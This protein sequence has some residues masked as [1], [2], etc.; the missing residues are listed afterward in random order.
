MIRF[1]VATYNTHKSRGMDWRVRP[2]RIVQVLR[3][4][5]AD[6]VA[7]QE[8]IAD[9]LPWL[10]E[11]AGMAHVFGAADHIRGNEYGNLLLSRFPVL[12]SE[13]YDVSVERREPRRC[14]RVDVQ[15]PGGPLLHIFAVHLGTSWFERRRQALR[16]TEILEKTE[17][18]GCRVLL[19]DFNEWT[20]GLS[21]R[22]LSERLSANHSRTY[23]GMIPFLH[24]DH[25]YHD[26]ELRLTALRRHRT[27]A[28]LLASDHLPLV[29]DLEVS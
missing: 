13:N 6:I 15:P 25:I 4:V 22:M 10:A 21:T 8:V 14:L 29:A 16:L 5:D 12:G 9:Q 27:R 28:S 18:A 24:L 11:H 3:E 2:E 17:L 23:P 7:L 26:P 1:R 20:R 19:G